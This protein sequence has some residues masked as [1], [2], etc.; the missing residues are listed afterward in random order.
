MAS[1]VVWLG[2]SSSLNMLRAEPSSAQS[3]LVAFSPSSQP[4]RL[5]TS[6]NWVIYSW[7]GSR[8]A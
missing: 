6:S 2:S 3:R 5:A 4:F 7:T 1:Y 8:P